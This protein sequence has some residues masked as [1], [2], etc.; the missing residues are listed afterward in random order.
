MRTHEL[1]VLCVRGRV[2]NSEVKEVGGIKLI[3]DVSFYHKSKQ[4]LMDNVSERCNMIRLHRKKIN[5]VAEWKMYLRFIWK[6]C[7]DTKQEAPAAAQGKDGGGS[8]YG[9]GES[10]EE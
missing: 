3:K 2:A 8:K 7:L 9:G 4:Q 6:E 5:L 10:C 1:R